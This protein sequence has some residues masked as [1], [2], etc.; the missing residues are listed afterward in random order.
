MTNLN[1]SDQPLGPATVKPE[2]AAQA[3]ETAGNPKQPKKPHGRTAVIMAVI[4]LAAIGGFTQFNSNI[5]PD[6][7]EAAFEASLREA[8]EE[9]EEYYR[10]IRSQLPVCQDEQVK[11]ILRDIL[12]RNGF[13]VVD[14]YAVNTQFQQFDLSTC[15]ATVEYLSG[16]AKTKDVTFM[17]ATTNNPREFMV[18]FTGLVE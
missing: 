4:L 2:S 16:E 12:D 17:V 11:D 18:R 6:Q 15:S 1:H 10:W 3:A 9:S 14:L 7:S 8:R 5:K 13:Q